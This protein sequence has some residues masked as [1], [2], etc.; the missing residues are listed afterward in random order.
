[1]DN[2]ISIAEYAVLVGRDPATIRQRCLRGTQPGAKKIGRDW[3]IPADA[4]FVDHRIKS[5]QYKSWRK[6]GSG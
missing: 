5:G 1:M 3:V 6:K 2:L 4:P